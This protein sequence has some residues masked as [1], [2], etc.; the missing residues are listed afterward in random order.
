VSPVILGRFCFRSLDGGDS[1]T[2]AS[3]LFTGVLPQHPECGASGEIYSAIDGY[4]P[5]PDPTDGSLYVM[6]ACGGHTYLARS[7]DEA[8]TFPI[9][10]ANGQPVVIPVPAPSTGQVGGPDLRIDTVGTMY[11][12]WAAAS[13]G[14]TKLLLGT[15]TDHGSTWSSPLDVTAPGLTV[16][17]WAMAERGGALAVA[18]LGQTQGQT[19]W[20]A[21][22][23]E[24]KNPLD[25]QPVFWS[26]AVND[27]PILYGSSIQ[28]SGY[29]PLFDGVRIPFPPPFGNQ[30]FGNDF[31]GATIAPDG[32]AWGSFDQDCGPTP[33]SSGCRTQNDQTR[34]F[35]GRLVWP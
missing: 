14:M 16:D 15:S 30:M 2:L 11:L 29:L 8:A 12:M 24:T 26:A 13:S 27:R 21:Y 3:I 33:D 19:T 25:A 17:Q 10:R 18:Y 5:Q 35:A 4:Y 7:V 6:V 1:F 34:G 23:T 28:G 31:I 20:D 32:S 22:I 9:V